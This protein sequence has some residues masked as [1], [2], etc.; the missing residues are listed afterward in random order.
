MPNSNI[1]VCFIAGNEERLID[2]ALDAAFKVTP[3]VVVVRAIGGK[4]PDKTLA[5][6]K[7]RGCAVAEYH[8]SLG[9]ARWPFVD[10]FAAARNLA[11]RL[12]AELVGPEG[13]LMW[14]DCDD[15]LSDNAGEA[16][17]NAIQN[18]KE[19]WLLVEYRLPSHGKSVWRERIFRV[20]SAAWVNAVHEKCIPLLSSQEEA[21]KQ[22]NMPVRVCRTFAVIHLPEGDKAGSQERN[23][24]ILRWKD[25]EV[26]HIKFY[27]HYEHFLIGR[28][29][30]AV[31][32]GLEALRMGNLCPVYRYEVLL[33]MSL[34]AEKNEHGQDLLQR[35]IKLNP[36]RREAH[37]LLA[38]LQMDAAQYE[39]AI[40]T[41]H[42]LL[43]IPEPKMHEWTHRPDIYGW[44]AHAMLA[45]AHRLA[46]QEAKA[47]EIE[48]AMLEQGG[49]PRISLLHA[50][51]GRWAQAITTMNTWLNH[52]SNAFHVE[53]IFA[54][55]EDDGLSRTQL[56]RF[57]HVVC[58][59]DG[60]SVGAWNKAAQA[61][62]GD[63]LIQLS[64]DFVA[65]PNWDKSLLDVLGGQLF[66]PAVVRVS[67]G[68]RNDG[69]ITMAI[70]TRRW[71][72]REGML[73][74]PEFRNVYSDNDLTA[75]ALRA[76]A[77][78]EAPHLVFEH[79]HPLAGKA[80][81][82]ATYER[83]NSIEEYNRAQ[84]IYANKHPEQ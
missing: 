68:L 47:A 50:T 62:T 72:E 34:L 28:R 5:I 58:P 14:M 17:Q 13:W 75:R 70:V 20:G 64:D 60:Y 61:A 79:R 66:A 1:A 15:I 63:V 69:L 35:A 48:A 78:V 65:P 25:E 74:D 8:N 11:F 73:F 18:C 55:D 19:S 6:A 41:C 3:N 59:A 36:D 51:R 40:E 22:E 9:T 45:W 24:N 37:G 4:T 32:Y 16:I 31:R 84:K 57:R 49:R 83:G 33:N 2:R 38:S 52:A 44:K 23:I 42:K 39:Q 80:A 30:E 10:D 29:E 77:I 26:H 7:Q 21:L 81:P 43:S 27:L 56:A 76:N 53:H 54:I 46:G 12:G 82:D 67:D 71:L